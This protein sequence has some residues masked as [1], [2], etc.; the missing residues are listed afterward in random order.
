MWTSTPRT[1]VPSISLACH[2]VTMSAPPGAGR[3][4]VHDVLVRKEVADLAR[5][6]RP[7]RPDPVPARQRRRVHHQDL[8]DG[9]LWWQAIDLADP[10]RQPA[11][12]LLAHVVVNTA[13]GQD[14]VIVG[15]CARCTSLERVRRGGQAPRRERSGQAGRGLNG[16]R[17]RQRGGRPDTVCPRVHEPGRHVE[18][19]ALLQFGRAEHV[20]NGPVNGRQQRRRPV[21]A[22]VLGRERPVGRDA[23]PLEQ[24]GRDDRQHRGHD[25]T[26]EGT[27]AAA[28]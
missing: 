17:Q 6:G 9:Q 3:L 26:D 16:S 25:E 27:R 18:M 1:P 28:R 24:R 2:A 12:P 15:R 10:V 4:E 11:Q 22:E 8:I 21:G 13:V 14:E 19:P 7:P 20:G 23:A 5:H